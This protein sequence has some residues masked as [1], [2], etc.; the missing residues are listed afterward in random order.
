MVEK[1]V[2]AALDIGTTKV[3]C[4]IAEV[5]EGGQI[6]VVGIGHQASAGL[7]AGTV[8]EMGPAE[9]AVLSAVHAAERMAGTTIRAVV[10]GTTGGQPQS[11]T[12]LFEVPVD[13]AAIGDRDIRRVLERGGMAPQQDGRFTIHAIPVGFAVDGTN[14]SRDP[15]GLHGRMLGVKLHTL[16]ANIGTVRNLSTCVARCHLDVADFALAPYAA[17]LGVL[18]DDEM[19]L[20]VTVIDMGG[21]TTSVAVFCDGALIFADSVPI[22]GSHVTSD[23]ARGLST[24]L[25]AAERVKTLHG[26]CLPTPSDEHEVIGVPQVGEEDEEQQYPKS[27][28]VRIIA[29]RVEETLELVRSQLVAAGADRLG[30]RRVVLTGGASQLPGV[31]ELAGFIL[32]KQVRLGRPIGVTGL[33]EA[34]QGPEFAVCTGLLSYAVDDRGET[35]PGAASSGEPRTNWLGRIGGWFRENF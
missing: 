24:P 26:S 8:V 30:G 15:R 12:A 14:G 29:P 21:G 32:D 18:V 9:Q 20:G 34:T 25:W 10:V 11:R 6:R 35:R 31:R 5:D 13:S 23:I 16:T 17:G 3:C 33:A 4:F 28:L 22:G 19:D 27:H 1:T 7:R 2:V